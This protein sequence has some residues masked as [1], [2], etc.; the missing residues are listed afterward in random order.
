[1]F[2]ACGSGTLTNFALLTVRNGEFANLLPRVKR[3][4]LGEYKF[5][6]L[7][8]FSSLPA[9]ATAYYAWGAGEAHFGAHRYC[10]DL[11]IFD[12]N[13]GAYRRRVRYL[14]SKKYPGLDEV[15]TIHVLDSEK[16]TI[17]AKLQPGTHNEEL[18]PERDS[19]TPISGHA[20]VASTALTSS[21][22]PSTF[23]R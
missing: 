12:P 4:N 22:V 17:L 15:E 6:D 11:Y 18:D 16:P 9:L 23:C 19:P 5:W 1:M 21:T 7:A 10:I 2:S 8:Q 20:A 14:T 3:T 13:S